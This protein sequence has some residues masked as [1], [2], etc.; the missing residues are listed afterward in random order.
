VNQTGVWAL[1]SAFHPTSGLVS[2]VESVRDQVDVVVVVDDGSGPGYEDVLADLESG[3]VRVV[4]CAVNRG[5]AAALNLA[6]EMAMREGATSLLTVDQDSRVPPDFVSRLHE[7]SRSAAAAG[8]R[9]GAV[10]PEWFAGVRQ[11]R[12]PVTAGFGEAR[13][14]IQSGMLIPS[15]VVRTVGGLRDDFFIDRVDT[16][17]ALRLHSSGLSVVAAPG[18]KIDH[19]L[20]A[21][22]RR[23]FFGR[24]AP[25][26][27]Q[28]AVMTLSTP[29]RYF[30]RVRNRIVLNRLYWRQAP[31]RIARDT[32]LDAAHFVDAARVARPRREMVRVMRAG[33]LAGVRGRMGRMPAAL[34][35]TAARI[36]WAAPPV[37]DGGA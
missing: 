26:P 32:V 27:A 25:V 13:D 19:A 12:G 20:G 23:E 11:A 29:F 33:L 22:Y 4:R 15:E 1:F 6:A 5:I 28:M 10:V 35:R 18:L 21:R 16:E 34:M 31:F 17:F 36:V 30:Y 37:E 24:P 7:A 8:V 2:A 9:V 3:G 14:A